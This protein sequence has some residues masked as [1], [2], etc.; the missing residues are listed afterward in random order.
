[1][2]EPEPMEAA[3]PEAAAQPP[4]P[5]GPVSVALL[6][7][8]SGPSADLGAALF[9]AAQLA[10]FDIGAEQLVLLPKDTEGTADGAA[11]AAAAAIAEGAS[12]ILGPLFSGS[13]A[14]VTPIAIDAGVNVVAFSSDRK[15]ARP[16]VFVM[17]FLPGQQVERVVEFASA[18]GLGRF[19]ALAPASSY[20]QTVVH[21][22][23]RVTKAIG[24]EFVDVVFYPSDARTASEVA[25]I[26]RVFTD[27]DARRQVLIAQRQRLAERDDEV[28]RRALRRLEALDTLGEVHFDAV[29]LPEGGSRLL[30]VAS[31]IPYYDVD[32]VRVRLLGT[33]QWESTALAEEPALIG[34]WFAAP[35]PEARADFE[36]RFTAAYGRPPPRL[37]TLAYDAVALAGALAQLP[38]GANFSAAML[39]TE[40]GFRGLDGLFRFFPDGTNARGLAVLEVTGNGVVTVGEAPKNFAAF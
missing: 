26:V 6:L 5:S 30:T 2:A 9:D 1:M 31:L 15:V 33:A 25:D 27:Y 13:V 11:R 12:L 14:T 3:A 40:G 38:G 18:R 7:P 16:G 21:E 32:P 8:L 35:P 22:L 37:A 20:G 4:L 24:R 19:A 23:R 29:L 17:G 10:L 28:S 34:G 36:A 39:T